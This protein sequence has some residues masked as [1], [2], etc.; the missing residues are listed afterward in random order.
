MVRRHDKEGEATP[1]T[2]YFQ[3][4]PAWV[5]MCIRATRTSISY[6][7]SSF[8]S[9][10]YFRCYQKDSRVERSETQHQN[11]STGARM[12]VKRALGLLDRGS[13][14]GVPVD[15]GGSDITVPEQF[16]DRPDIVVRQEQM[17]GKAVAEGMGRRGV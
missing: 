16:L 1:Q 13:L 8:C 4:H 2:G 14:D 5:F 11:P 17:T 12:E 6:C 10:E 7:G 15:H 3:R 9:I